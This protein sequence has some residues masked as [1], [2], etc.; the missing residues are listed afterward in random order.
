MLRRFVV[1]MLKIVVNIG[2]L[3]TLCSW[4]LYFLAAIT[5]FAMP[6]HGNY[7]FPVVAFIGLGLYWI[8]ASTV[9]FGFASL[10]IE[11]NE[12][13]KRMVEIRSQRQDVRF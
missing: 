8:I 11:I 12:N 4:L 1:R 2:I 3:I 5:P 13:L 9:V 10:F 7:V 6:L